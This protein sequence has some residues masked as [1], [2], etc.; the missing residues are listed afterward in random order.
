MEL[1]RLELGREPYAIRVRHVGHKQRAAERA[2]TQLDLPGQGHQGS[3]SG[4]RLAVKPLNIQAVGRKL[5]VLAHP[6]SLAHQNHRRTG[7]TREGHEHILR[8]AR[9]HELLDVRFGCLTHIR[10]IGSVIEVR[11]AP[12]LTAPFAELAKAP[13]V[14][15]GRGN[16]MLCVNP[17]KL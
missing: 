8:I 16:V 7:V 6:V 12:S 9:S 5:D 15:T 17:W 2:P 13:W 11:E 4:N 14:C 1:L 10:G 3:S